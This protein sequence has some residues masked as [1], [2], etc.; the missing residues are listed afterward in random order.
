MCWCRRL[1][2]RE[3]IIMEL[4]KLQTYWFGSRL[5]RIPRDGVQSSCM[6]AGIEAVVSVPD[7]VCKSHPLQTTRLKFYSLVAL[8]KCELKRFRF[9][10]RN[11]LHNPFCARQRGCFRCQS[12]FL[13]RF[14]AG[15]RDLPLL[16]YQSQEPN[17]LEAVSTGPAALHILRY[18]NP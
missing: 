13:S 12:P 6:T 14:V 3:G 11:R 15:G 8:T 5:R 10:A 16:S 1:W 18:M 4:Q 2:R 9:L 17:P 7:R